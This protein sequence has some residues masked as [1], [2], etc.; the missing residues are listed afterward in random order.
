[1]SKK[2][3][4]PAYFQHFK[5]G[6]YWYFEN[7]ALSLIGQHCHF[8]S[9]CQ[10]IRKKLMKQFWTKSKKPYFWAVFAPNLPPKIFFENRA[11]S[12]FEHCH[13]TPLCQKSE[14]T[15][16]PIL[17][18]AENSKMVKG[19]FPKKRKSVIND[20]KKFSGKNFFGHILGY[21]ALHFSAKNQKKLMKQFCSKS[22]K[23]YFQAV[24]DPNLPNF[25]WKSG[26][27]T[28]WALPY[29]TFVPKISKK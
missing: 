4:F 19:N 12:L 27:I 2:K 6:K 29:C 22:K 3:V 23:P 10:K 21:F 11:P 25:F 28:F 13:F 17:R 7:L 14:K 5:T 16:E 1:M 9:L 20:E 18:K 15:N 24:F 8:G 26:F